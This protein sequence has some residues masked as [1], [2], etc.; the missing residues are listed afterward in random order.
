[1]ATVDEG[2]KMPNCDDQTAI[3]SSRWIWN[4]EQLTPREC[5]VLCGLVTSKSNGEI[6]KD[7]GVS[8]N[9]VKFHTKNI[10]SKWGVARRMDL[11]AFLTSPAFAGKTG[12]LVASKN[13]KQ[14][15][16]GS[17]SLPIL[18]CFILEIGRPSVM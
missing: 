11:I 14:S 1:M 6:A 18:N 3:D 16:Y 5:D 9:T 13:V 12:H 8:L 4:P 10:Y 2:L 17:M 15:T 7:L